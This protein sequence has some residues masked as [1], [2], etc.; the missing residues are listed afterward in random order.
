MNSSTPKLTIQ[1]KLNTRFFGDNTPAL[2]VEGKTDTMVYERLLI[3]SQLDWKEI[4]IVIG[5]SKSN[6]LKHHDQGLPFK[7][8]ALL[9]ADYDYYFDQI[10]DDDN[11]I[12]TKFYNMENYLTTKNVLKRII[13][14]F[15]SVSSKHIN[16]DDILNEAIEAII[17]F[18]LSCIA[19]IK[20]DL[21]I[22]LE[23]QNIERWWHNSEKR[24]T[25][26][27]MHAYIDD[28]LKKRDFEI[29]INWSELNEEYENLLETHSIDKFL[30]GKHKLDAIYKMFKK[31]FPDHMAHRGIN[32][33]KVDLIRH[34]NSCTHANELL[35]SIDYRFQK[36]LSVSL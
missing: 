33:F 25:I 7:Y 2:I 18:I 34:I 12:Y 16:E 23:D 8:V 26:S 11:L 19:K 27:N 13:K 36:I 35:D 29:D 31:H 21:P 22:S 20:Y 4:D 6:I 24:I 30:N 14:D 10:I 28:E 17:P 9:D 32:P 1:D 3:N 15:N 5:L